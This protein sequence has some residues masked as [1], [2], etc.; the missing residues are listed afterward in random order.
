VVFII[1]ARQFGSGYLSA[2][3]N[4]FERRKCMHWRIMARYQECQPAC[5]SYLVALDLVAK[6]RAEM[7]T[8]KKGGSRS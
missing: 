7:N 4:F 6:L 5:H 3:E 2:G 8:D 1:S